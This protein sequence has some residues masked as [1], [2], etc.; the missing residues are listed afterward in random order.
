MDKNKVAV[1]LFNKLA[2]SYQERFM[3][4][5]LY[6]DTFDFFCDNIKTENAEILELACG[7]GNITQYLLNKRPDFKVLGT[8]LAPN[9][10]ELAQKNNPKATF[11]LMDCRAIDTIDKKYDA[12]MCGFCLPYLDKTETTKLIQN[13]SNILKP[14]GLLYLSTMEGDYDT[15]GLRK[16][17]TGEEIFMHYYPA[18]FLIKTL[19]NNHLNVIHLSRKEYP[20]NDGTK[21]TDLIIIADLNK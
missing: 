10:I 5:N 8:D 13:A 2:E 17:S 14:K 18:D 7:P 12:I 21:I 1:N 15:S 4:V 11:Q 16:G 3:D 9:M 19:E 6:G 20:A